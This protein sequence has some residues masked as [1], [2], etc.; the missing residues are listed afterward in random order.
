MKLTRV[1]S[2]QN[3][4]ALDKLIESCNTI[5]AAVHESQTIAIS[6]GEAGPLRWLESCDKKIAIAGDVLQFRITLELPQVEDED[7][8]V[9]VALSR[10]YSPNLMFDQILSTHIDGNPSRP[11]NHSMHR[12][13]NLHFNTV[14]SGSTVV[15]RYQARVDCNADPLLVAVDDLNVRWAYRSRSTHETTG[16]AHKASQGISAPH[17]IG[18]ANHFSHS[19]SAALASSPV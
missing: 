5:Q 16:R 11:T 12:N 9:Q 17:G 15:V 3:D 19:K 14:Q 4:L 1:D 7:D 2:P 8:V 18:T 13:L 6:R 10:S